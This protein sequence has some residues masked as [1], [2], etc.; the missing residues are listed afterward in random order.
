LAKAY[1]AAVAAAY[2]KELLGEI[3]QALVEGTSPA[4]AAVMRESLAA[5]T[6]FNPVLHCI[7]G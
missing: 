4:A 1:A 5:V 6:V 3:E 7:Y 2:T